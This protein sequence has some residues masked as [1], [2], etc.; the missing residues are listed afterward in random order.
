MNSISIEAPAKLNLGLAITGVRADGFHSLASYFTKITLAD[1]L[2]VTLTVKKGISITCSGI[3]VPADKNNIV[4]KAASLFMKNSGYS[5]GISVNLEKIIPSP[6]GLG[7]GSSD[8]AS[9]LIALQKLTKTNLNL[10]TMAE[11]LG[12]D[13]PFFLLESNSAF[14]TG[15]GE[16]LNPIELPGFYCL[17]VNSGEQVPTPL[18]YE[19]WDQHNKA[20]TDTH[21]FHNNTACNFGAWHEGKPFPVKLDNSFFVPLQRR[22]PGFTHTAENLSE[23][24]DN[25]GLSGSGPVFYA[26]FQSGD[27]AKNAKKHFTG[28]FPWMFCCQSR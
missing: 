26:L 22:F 4:W 19:L 13:V 10:F 23:V 12:S 28:K 1:R 21:I 24:T 5:D 2:Q 27:E 16:I 15:R 14:V 8:A 7:G 25:W 6:G 20:L 18:A 9:T 17:L 11:L 3:D